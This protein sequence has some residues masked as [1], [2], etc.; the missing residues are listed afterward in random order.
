MKNIEDYINMA[1]QAMAKQTDHSY[2]R[3]S[4]VVRAGKLTC[5][6]ATGKMMDDVHVVTFT[7]LQLVTG[8]TTAE[9][10]RVGNKVMKIMKELRP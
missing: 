6:A 9:W 10:T 8:F 5:I 2:Y 1:E 3:Y 4:L 7:H